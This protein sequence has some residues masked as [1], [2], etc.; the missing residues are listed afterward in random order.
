MGTGH[1]GQVGDI[2]VEAGRRPMDRVVHCGTITPQ[3]YAQLKKIPPLLAEWLNAFPEKSI[4]CS[5]EQVCQGAKCEN[6]L[7]CPKNWILC[8]ITYMFAYLAI[9]SG[10]HV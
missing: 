4:G 6:V 5:V 10:G 7:N 3:R 1:Q 9:D 8:D 2:I